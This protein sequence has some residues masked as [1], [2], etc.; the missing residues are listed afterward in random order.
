MADLASRIN[1]RHRWDWIWTPVTWLF[2]L[3][4][5]API[6]WMLWCSLMGN[7]E[8]LQGKTMPDPRPTDVFMLE[9]GQEGTLFAGTIHGQFYQFDPRELPEIRRSY[10]LESHAADYLKQGNDLWVLD[11][12]NGLRALDL[13]TWKI[14]REYDWDWMQEQYE[15]EDHT[16]YI[17]R[18]TGLHT[19]DSALAYW[20]N[21]EPLI[22]GDQASKS[23]AEITGI[24]FPSNTALIDSLNQVLFHPVLVHKVLD[25][26]NGYQ[27]W[28]NPVIPWLFEK[29]Q[30]T[31]QESRQLFRWCFAERY[32]HLHTRFYQIEWQS[33]WVN[34]IPAS[35][36]GTTVVSCG[37]NR[38][39]LGLWWDDFPGMGILDLETESMRWITLRHGLPSSAIQHIVPVQE[40][41]VLVVTDA[42][43]TLV[44]VKQG[45]ILKTVLFGEAGVPFLDGR[46]MRVQY[47]NDHEILLA[48]SQ[49]LLRFDYREGMAVPVDFEPLQNLTSDITA[50]AMQGEKFFLGTSQ[51]M[52]VTD[53]LFEESFVLDN[54]FPGESAQ[55][56]SNGVIH[57]IMPVGNQ[58]WVG[59]RNGVVVSVDLDDQVVVQEQQFPKGDLYLHW[60]NYQD[61][62]RTIPF[63]TFLRNSLVIC[64]SVMFISMLV[65]SLASYALSRY[66]FPGKKIFSGA[67][68]STQMIP[69]IL[70][71]IPIFIVFTAVQQILTIQLVNTWH[72]IILVYASFYIPMST[73]ILRGFFAGIP[74]ELEE[75]ALMDGCS[76]LGAFLRITVPAALPG[77]VA[78]GIYVFL[79]AWDELMFAWVLS[80]DLSTATIPVGIRLYVGQFGNR[81]DLL[82]AAASVATLP[83]MVLF[84]LMQKQIVTGLT[85]GAV[86]G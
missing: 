22:Q 6:L 59:S 25:V 38:L 28:I 42:G 61:L 39:C 69:G 85:G 8:I 40:D 19:N 49:E 67:I 4:N 68:L 11:A 51:G 56:R 12:N 45:E 72:G 74:R 62:W 16:R 65:A 83:V 77:I 76:P 13:Q 46:E 78:T 23:L 31:E 52:W 15:K 14:S 63:G 27:G 24:F 84:F 18:E 20:I 43:L 37:E 81:F 9:Q 48:Y 73:W 29:S 41:E 71:L 82:M 60:R 75:A 57:K 80:T 2:V 66:S 10:D 47:L 21:H 1:T 86:K 3:V 58:V 79:L 55:K 7:N 35:G 34:R 32:P 17:H 33:L 70:Y 5:A 36:N 26:W 53:T 50:L 54:L 30:R 64:L 44:N